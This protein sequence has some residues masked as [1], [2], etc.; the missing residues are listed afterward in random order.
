MLFE[1]VEK[2]KIKKRVRVEMGDIQSLMD[3]LQ[4]YGLINPIVLTQKNQLIAG[5]RRLTAARNLG[6]KK[7]PV[8]KL[9]LT[10]AK[11]KLE[12]EIEENI[13]RKDFTP[14]EMEAAFLELTK[15]S[16]PGFWTRLWKKIVVFF[17]RLFRIENT[18]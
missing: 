17:K 13:R 6:W 8:V 5:H 15:L 3:S 4:K 1:D 10:G 2:I 12:W 18:N 7:V 9:D 16:R 11:E 14:E